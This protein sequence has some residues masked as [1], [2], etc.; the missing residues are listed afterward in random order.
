MAIGTIPKDANLRPGC[1]S[2]HGGHEQFDLGRERV[3]LKRKGLSE[4]D[5]GVGLAADVE[6]NPDLVEASGLPVGCQEDGA[7]EMLAAEDFRPFRGRQFRVVGPRAWIVPRLHNV[8]GSENRNK[9]REKD[10]E[11]EHRPG[12]NSTL[13]PQGFQERRLEPKGRGNGRCA[14]SSGP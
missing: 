14:T 3:E 9:H 8:V 7:R 5:D 6:G 4:H 2:E 12:G 10:Q 13:G 11:P 1:V